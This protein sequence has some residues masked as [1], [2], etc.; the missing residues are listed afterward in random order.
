[1]YGAL[2]ISTSGM[3]AERTRMTVISANLAGR[4]TILDAQGNV[5][6]YRKRFAIFESGDPNAKNKAAREMGVHVK[7]I[8]ADPDAVR[9]KH[10]PTHPFAY[11]DGP[12]AGYVPVPDIDP[13]TEQVD[14]MEALRS[15]EANVIA[16]EATKAMMAQ[17]IRLIA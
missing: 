7:E 12:N 17:A 5:N 2:D 1:M 11:K 6:P 9:L 10:D 3:I 14:A 15:Y 13:I 16:A 4:E 8:W